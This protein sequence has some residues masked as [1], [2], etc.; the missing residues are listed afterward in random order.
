MRLP[1]PRYLSGGRPPGSHGHSCRRS[2][3]PLLS[4]GNFLRI[5]L[6]AFVNATKRRGVTTSGIDWNGAHDVHN[7]DLRGGEEPHRG[8]PRSRA[9]AHMQ[10]PPPGDGVV[11]REEGKE[12]T[13]EEAKRKDLPVVGMPRELQVEFSPRGRVELRAVF[14]EDRESSVRAIPEE[15]GFGRA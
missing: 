10:D 13:G 3:K 15:G 14:E 6:P 7:G 4:S 5:V 1:P 11:P 2:R 9:A 8:P 12:Q